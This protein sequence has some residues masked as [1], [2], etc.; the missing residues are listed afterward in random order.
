MA[1]N[2]STKKN[3]RRKSGYIDS[4]QI[5]D[6][7]PLFSWLEINVTELCNRTCIFCPRQDPSFYPNQN[8]HLPLSLANKI[9]DEL[10]GLS[11]EGVVVLCG[12]GE[13][14]LHPTFSSIV[15][16]IS[17]NSRVEI[18]TN[19]DHLTS[20]NINKLISLGAS[21]FVV[22]MYD[23]PEQIEKFTNMTKKANVPDDLVI[24]RDRWYK[25]NHF[26]PVFFYF[27]I[28]Y[29]VNSF[30]SRKIIRPRN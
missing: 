4:V 9:S 12:Y 1:L 30:S 2:E 17:K 18:V 11:Y 22:S 7:W 5:Y 20:K 29:N 26:G 23:G 15:E 19:G 14:L 3:L 24:L 16:T 13:P 27:C 6:N 25:E 10:G 28:L 21:Y 8:L